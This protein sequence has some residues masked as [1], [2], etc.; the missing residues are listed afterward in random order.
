MKVKAMNNI[1]SY[2]NDDKV[3]LCEALWVRLSLDD[4]T[5]EVMQVWETIED[6][7]Y[8]FLSL[9]CCPDVE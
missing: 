2:C 4:D 5:D 9:D 1:K 6:F 8:F 3:G 7:P